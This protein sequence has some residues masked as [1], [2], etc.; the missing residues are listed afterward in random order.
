[1]IK[2]KKILGFSL[3]GALLLFFV[4]A[5][6]N[7]LIAFGENGKQSQKVIDVDYSNIDQVVTEVLKEEPEILKEIEVIHQSSV[8]V[9]NLSKDISIK[10][11]LDVDKTKFRLKIEDKLIHGKENND[12]E[13]L[14]KYAE[15]N[16]N[17]YLSAIEIAKKK[18]AVTVSQDEVTKYIEQNISVIK[19]AEKEKYAK[20]LGLTVQ[21][22]DY[23]FDRDIYL[24]DTLW[25]KVIPILME[26]YPQKD[27]EDQNLYNERIKEEFYK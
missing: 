17:N 5:S 21:E 4:I 15:K 27:G 18:Y 23:V 7:G 16:N 9:K 22:L 26:K 2:N 25:E 6:T 8:N 1:M 19:I 11:T 12:D 10:D 3:L 13:V 24:M 14:Q 20:A